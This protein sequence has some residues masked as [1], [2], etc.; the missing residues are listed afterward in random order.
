MRLCPSFSDRLVGWPP[1]KT[2]RARKYVKVAVDGA[3]YLRKVD[4]QMYNNH[5]QLFAALE[6]MFQGVVTIC[7]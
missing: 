1:V 6:N 2:V 7:K 5:D 3:A 4:L